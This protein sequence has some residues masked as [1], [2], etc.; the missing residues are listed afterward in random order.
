MKQSPGDYSMLTVKNV[1][2]LDGK[3]IQIEINADKDSVFDAENRYTVIPSV[4]DPHFHLDPKGNDWKKITQAAVAGGVSVLCCQNPDKVTGSAKSDLET[5]SKKIDEDLN[6]AG[7]LLKH[8][9][10]YAPDEAHLE[11]VGQVKQ[12]IIGLA[13]QLQLDATYENFNDNL[14]RIAAQEDLIV[15][16]DSDNQD[17]VKRTREGIR[18]TQ[19]YGAQSYFLDLSTPEELELIRQA[20]KSS[21]LIH[22]GISAENLFNGRH[23]DALWRGIGDGTIDTI[24]SGHGPGR[25]EGLKTL[26]PGLLKAVKTKKLK[27]EKLIALVRMNPA[28]MFRLSRNEDLLLVDLDK[29]EVG[30]MILSGSLLSSRS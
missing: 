9:F 29:A 23:Q 16:I 2:M 7:A 5:Q 21:L 14:F 22:T 17:R 8:H 20:R 27:I 13:T 24:G 4:I 28:N 10:Y 15:V 11:T 26:L 19:K 6:K 30:H 25:T 18:L 12:D 1:K 3:I